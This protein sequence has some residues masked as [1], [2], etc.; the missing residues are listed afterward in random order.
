MSHLLSLQSMGATS[1]QTLNHLDAT[2]T[3]LPTVSHDT[4]D[5]KRLVVPWLHQESRLNQRFEW[6]ARVSLA[7]RWSQQIDGSHNSCGSPDDLSRLAHEVR[8]CTRLFRV[9]FFDLVCI[10][11]DTGTT[12]L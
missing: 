7:R 5:T 10:S 12:D 11:L 9:D 8:K 4:L 3:E 6:I 2:T 1:S